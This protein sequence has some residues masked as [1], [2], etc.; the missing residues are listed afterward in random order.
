MIAGKH[1]RCSEYSK[2]PHI[3]V[4]DWVFGVSSVSK[5]GFESPVASPCPAARSSLTSRLRRNP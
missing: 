5:D 1:A 4:D 3:R 2:L